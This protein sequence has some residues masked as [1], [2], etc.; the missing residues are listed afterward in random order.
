MKLY[1]LIELDWQGGKEAKQCIE[2]IKELKA[3]IHPDTKF[4]FQ[5]RWCAYHKPVDV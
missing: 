2:K 1:E 3:V 4:P 5:A